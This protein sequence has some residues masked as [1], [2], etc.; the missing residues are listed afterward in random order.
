MTD[1]SAGHWAYEYISGLVNRN[2]VNGYTQPDGS[3]RFE[4]ANE[5][6]RAE[7]M[8]LIVVA[9]NLDLVDDYDG[10]VFSDW[11]QVEDWAKPYVAALLEAGIVMGSREGSK[12]NINANSNVTREEMITMT[13]RALDVELSESIVEAPDFELVSDWASCYV[14]FALENSMINLDSNYN[15]NPITN[16]KRDETAMILY[17]LLTYMGA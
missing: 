7:L 4:P 2:I 3:L 6:T 9:L 17:K 10:S 11:G 14:A 13:V 16:A 15:V 12:V 8:K 1:V 5:I